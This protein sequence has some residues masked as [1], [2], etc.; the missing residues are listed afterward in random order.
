[1][2]LKLAPDDHASSV[3]ATFT[4]GGNTINTMVYVSG[5]LPV[6]ETNVIGANGV[7]WTRVHYREH[8]GP[9]NGGVDVD[10]DGYV[11]NDLVSAPHAPGAP[12]LPNPTA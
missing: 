10:S 6:L 4:I 8:I 2:T 12:A 11:R 7:R 1:M 3:S 9:L 5:E